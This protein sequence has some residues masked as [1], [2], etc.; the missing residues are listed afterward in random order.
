MVAR[1]LSARLTY[2]DYVELP[3][4]GKRYEIHDGELSVTPAPGTRHQ[5]VS[6]R[7]ASLLFSH[8][9]A[10]AL[11]E[12]YHAPVDVILDRHTVVQPDIVFVDAARLGIV[13]ERGIEGAPTL[14]V[15]IL[16]SSTTRVDRATKFR[17][18]A[19]FGVP[20]YWIVDPAARTVEAYALGTSG[21]GLA[22]HATGSEPVSPAPFDDL[23][24]VPDA[25]WPGA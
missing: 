18:Y 12:V 7:L 11:G 14:V 3:N 15:E 20:H 9:S 21:Y 17:L 19:R 10:H 2:E 6:I 16:S 23:G 22:L 1:D 8:A 13:A 4:D 24:L 5:G 25:L